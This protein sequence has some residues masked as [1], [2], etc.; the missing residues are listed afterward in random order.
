MILEK[1]SELQLNLGMLAELFGTGESLQN[2]VISRKK[3][4]DDKKSKK[5]SILDMNRMS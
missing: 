2:S 1:N 4:Q 3:G 5:V